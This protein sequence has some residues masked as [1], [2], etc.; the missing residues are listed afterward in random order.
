[1][2][3]LLIMLVSVTAPYEDITTFNLGFKTGYQYESM[4][5]KEVNV[6][7]E[8]PGATP[9][10]DWNWD[11]TYT[12]KGPGGKTRTLQGFGF[13]LIGEL[14]MAL[15][16]LPIGVEVDV[17]H[18]TSSFEGD[19]LFFLPLSS[20]FSIPEQKQVILDTITNY[21][22]TVSSTRAAL[23]GKLFIRSFPAVYPWIGLGPF[24]TL[25]THS[26]K[27]YTNYYDETTSRANL[28]ICGELGARIWI[29]SKLSV[30]AGVRI[31]YFTNA[32][33]TFKEK[34]DE[35]NPPDD[36]TQYTY[37]CTYSQWNVRFMV[38][39][40]YAIKWGL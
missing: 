19:T 26:I 14:V 27:P 1:M 30:D 8:A 40:H 9:I 32:V 13:E 31:D 29:L 11:S 36:I 39:A 10:A 4:R 6:T 21:T 34:Y 37:N 3:I 2:N 25:S 28:G 35:G 7:L 5:L 17:G 33:A 23:L 38:G 12:I 15:P 18:Y 22:Y 16:G 20:T 24:V